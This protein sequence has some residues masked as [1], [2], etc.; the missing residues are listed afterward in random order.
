MADRPPASERGQNMTASHIV[1]SL[2]MTL[3]VLAVG[4]S[5]FTASTPEAAPRARGEASS[6]MRITIGSNVFNATLRDSGTAKAFKAMLPLTVHLRDLNSN[7]K[8]VRLPGDL[9]RKDA[10]PGTIHS[11]DLMLY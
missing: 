9:P 2:A 1:S 3:A 11:G 6:R 8:H 4:A 7:E 10:S 5:P